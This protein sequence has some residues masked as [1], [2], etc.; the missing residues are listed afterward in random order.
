MLEYVFNF[1]FFFFCFNISFY[2]IQAIFCLIMSRIGWP[3]ALL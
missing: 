2:L 3:L 1:A